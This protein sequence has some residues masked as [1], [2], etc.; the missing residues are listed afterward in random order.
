VFLKTA[1]Q[2]KENIEYIKEEFGREYL[3]PLIVSKSNETLRKVLPY[4]QEKGYLEYLKNSASILNLTLEQIKER[5]TFIK[6]K[7]DSIIDE[8]GKFNSIFGLSK[9]KYEKRVAELKKGVGQEKKN[10]S[11]K[12]LARVVKDV[13]LTKVKEAQGI[14]NEITEENELEK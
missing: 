7:G 8:R 14:L 11:K 10:K 13:Q 4:L 1:E 5:E 3:L 9:K 2:L 12:S 6:E